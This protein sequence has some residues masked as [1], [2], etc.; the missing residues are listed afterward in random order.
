MVLLLQT[1]ANSY[2]FIL[3]QQG[4]QVKQ[5]LVNGAELLFGQAFARNLIAGA[6]SRRQTPRANL[7]HFECMLDFEAHELSDLVSLPKFLDQLKIGQI[8]HIVLEGGQDE[9]E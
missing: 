3:D 8:L 1:C 5:A 4:C 6:V 9:V 7:A 2:Y